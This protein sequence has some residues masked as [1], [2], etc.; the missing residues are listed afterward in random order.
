MAPLPEIPEPVLLEHQIAKMMATQNTVGWPFDVQKAQELENTL[1]TRLE[2][3]R[4]AAQEVCW[5]VPGNTFTPKRDNAKQGYVNGTGR[6]EL[7]EHCGVVKEI[8]ECSLTR[9][10]EFNPSSR[11]HISWWFKT[12]QNWTPKK[13]TP[14]GKPVIDEVVLKEIGTKEALIFA[15]ILSTQKKLGMLSQGQNAWLKL[16]KDGRLHHSCF[17]GAATHR[18][19]HARPNLAQVSSDKDCRELFITK[20]GWKLVDSDLA[21]I[22]LRMFAHYLARYDGGRYAKILLNGDIH[23]VNADKIGI[24]RKLVK[25]VTY[26]FLYG[27]GDRKIGVSYNSSLKDDAAARKGKEIRKAY[28]DAIPGLKDLVD[29]TKRVSESGTIRAIDG[30]H[31]SVNKGHKSLNF[32]LQ[33]SAAVIAKRWLLITNKYLIDFDIPHERYAFVHDEQVIGAPPSSAKDVATYCKWAANQAGEY[34]K[35]RLP[36]TADANTGNNWAEVH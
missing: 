19:A 16:V 11:D 26:A 4:K 25:T 35:L 12:F 7:H 21:G 15:E 6:T 32:L 33:S 22:E 30:R 9:L 3:L 18:M 31:I 36:I 20:P 29:A 14:T 2:G 23:Q 8:P 10:K 27:A 34:Y 13:K 28:M 17:I 1:L 5:C 24:S